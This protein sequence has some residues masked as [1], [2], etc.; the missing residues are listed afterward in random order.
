MPGL[1]KVFIYLAALF[2][3]V[4]CAGPIFL[5]LLGSVVPERAMF[6]HDWFRDGVNFD[7]YVFVFTG[8]VPREYRDLDGNIFPA[9]P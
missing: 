6:A 2:L 5:S 4:F 7:N 3:F 8:E 1:R 9:Y